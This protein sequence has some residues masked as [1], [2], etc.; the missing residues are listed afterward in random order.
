M[1]HSLVV[2]TLEAVSR[3][4]KMTVPKYPPVPKGL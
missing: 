2:L 4:F 1:L 3:E